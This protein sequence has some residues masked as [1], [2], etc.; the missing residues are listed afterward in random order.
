MTSFLK[1]A[2]LENVTLKLAALALALVLFA[3]V[4]SNR[5]AL[6]AVYMKVVYIY[7]TDRVLVTEPVPELRVTVRGSLNRVGRLADH[8]DFG[9]VRVDL[10]HAEDEEEL[11]FDEDLVKLPPGLRVETI[12]PSS[13]SLRFE[14]RVEKVVPVQ[15]V[16]EGEPASG[17]R[18]IRSAVE[19]RTVRVSGAKSVVEGIVRATTQPLR[20]SD[21]KENVRGQVALA[22]APSHAEWRDATLDAPAAPENLSIEV[23]PAIAEKRL[24]RV[25][26]QVVGARR[27]DAH[28]DPTTAEVVLRGPT[29]TLSKVSASSLSLM[30]DAQVE[31]QRAPGV[32]RKRP[33]V[34][35]LPGGVAAEVRPESVMLFTRR[36]KN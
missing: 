23:A 24:A 30:I 31:D 27:L 33:S 29:E 22:P 19:P 7:P 16:L 15:P 34:V 36:R 14:P 13:V 35:G 3:V 32:Y 4:R 9:A 28:P 18:V 10:R 6:T 5:D 21:A 25:P 8:D 17:Y 20:I 11:R 12:S 1:R 26:V 2:L